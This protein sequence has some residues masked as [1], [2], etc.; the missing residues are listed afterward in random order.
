MKINGKESLPVRSSKSEKNQTDTAF[1]IQ[2]C[3]NYEYIK[4]R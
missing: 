3:D 4:S 2:R 1:K